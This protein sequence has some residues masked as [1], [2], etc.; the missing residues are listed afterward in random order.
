MSAPGI[1]DDRAK[2]QE[3]VAIYRKVIDAC[4]ELHDEATATLNKFNNMPLEDFLEIQSLHIFMKS[5][6]HKPSLGHG[7]SPNTSGSSSEAPLKPRMGPKTPGQSLDERRWRPH[8]EDDLRVVATR[9][10][11]QSALR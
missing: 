9:Q 1:S 11:R 2:T 4:N 6:F 10:V 5:E 7:A 3:M 8:G